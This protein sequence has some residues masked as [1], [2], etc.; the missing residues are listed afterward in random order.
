MATTDQ[1]RTAL[2][3]GGLA[4]CASLLF[5]ISAAALGP[6]VAQ[7]AFRFVQSASPALT[8]ARQLVTP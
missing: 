5:L 2:Q 6:Q 4:G 1:P 7:P 8:P 3:R